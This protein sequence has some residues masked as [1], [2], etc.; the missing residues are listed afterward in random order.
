[1]GEI[2]ESKG[3]GE[4]KIWYK[5]RE[6]WKSLYTYTTR[7]KKVVYRSRLVPRRTKTLGK[8][9]VIRSRHYKG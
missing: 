3:A 2:I 5:K 1:V 8:R 4:C 7:Q 9:Y 6:K